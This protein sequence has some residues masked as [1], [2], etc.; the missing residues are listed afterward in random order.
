MYK[1]LSKKIAT[2]GLV[3]IGA[4]SMCLT[5][6]SS[7]TTKLTPG[8]AKDAIKNT[9]FFD[10]GAYTTRF[11]TGY[12]EVSESEGLKLS[13]LEAA[14]VI[15][16]KIDKI[17]ENKQYWGYEEQVPHYFATVALTEEG[18]KYVENT[19]YHKYLNRDFFETLMLDKQEQ[20]E[21]DLEKALPQYMKAANKIPTE[22]DSTNTS[23]DN[24][25]TNTNSNSY[26]SNSSGKVKDAYK[27]AL[28]AAKVDYVTVRMG[29]FELVDVCMVFCPEETAKVGKATCS[30][31]IKKTD[32]TPF[33]Y[34]YDTPQKD[35][36]LMFIN[37]E[38]QKYEDYGWV[39]TDL[40]D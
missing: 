17:I 40:K 18:Q 15:T 24:S 38:L 5:S 28:E 4:M 32:L 8:E 31:I 37:A 19:E 22:T 6:C 33:G 25:D 23:T 16:L 12:Y 21:K 1:S 27:T 34:V 39:I 30:Y 11:A 20:I 14:K 7:D 26:K 29:E 2:L 10:E 13:Q 3:A 35:K 36:Y 9:S